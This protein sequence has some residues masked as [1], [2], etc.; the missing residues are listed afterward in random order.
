MNSIQIP[1]H[2]F[3]EAGK[4]LKRLPFWKSKLPELTHV[5]LRTRE[6]NALF[7]TLA[8]VNLK[9]RLEV[10]VR[11]EDR[12]ANPTVFLIPIDA[13]RT[14]MKADKSSVLSF[15]SKGDGKSAVLNLKAVCGGI[16]VDA[17]YPAEPAHAFPLRPTIAGPST[18]I[19]ARTFEQLAVAAP[20]ASTDPTREVLNGVF[21]TPEDGGLLVATDGRKLTG[22]PATVPTSA[23][24]VLPTAAVRVLGHRQFLREASTVTVSGKGD[25]QV[26][27]FHTKNAILISE[28]LTGR[29]PKWRQVV[30][31]ESLAS[32]TL[33]ESDRKS[34]RDWLKT[35]KGT[36][37]SV[38][39]RST[40]R[41]VLEV[42][43][44]V[45]REPLATVEVP[46]EIE[47][48]L[49]PLQV[50]PQSLAIALNVG[51]TLCFT[52][53]MSPVVARNRE[54]GFCVVMP[55]RLTVLPESKEEQRCELAAAA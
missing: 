11:M 36:E 18:L 20:C 37:G 28:T 31:P 43:H 19:P 44:A 32:A 2:A 23:E 17:N 47:G 3:K 24:F 12:V 21:F 30:P 34:L 40:K 25:E 8:V 29:F 33:T 6:E 51:P 52:D 4:I 48:N 16:T 10:R 7:A 38:T 55:M 15:T 50:N 1:A 35:L 42:I 14:A 53:S 54:G 27:C 45:R 26:V 46:V 41:G 39:L 9:Q 49:P 13:F 5:E 22:I